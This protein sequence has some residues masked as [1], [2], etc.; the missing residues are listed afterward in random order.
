MSAANGVPRVAI[1]GGGISGLAAALRLRELAQEQVRPLDVHLL[2]GGE[3][4]G[5]VIATERRDG[6]LLEAGP[7]SFIT[8]KP[9]ALDL[10]RRLGLS[11]RLIGT[12][13]AHRRSYVARAGRLYPVPEGFQLLA[14][15]R[16]GP[17]L[18]SGLFSWPGKLRMALEPFVPAR[19]SGEDE[20]LAEFVERRLGR[21]AL[22]RIAQPMVAGIYGADP[23]R[24][25]LQATLP[26]FLKMEQEHGSLL[27]AMWAA[28]RR[29]NPATTTENAKTRRREEHEEGSST[30]TGVSGARY[31]LF[32]SFDDGMQT[33]VDALVARLPAGCVSLGTRI[34]GLQREQANWQ[35]TTIPAASP[36]GAPLVGALSATYDAVCLALP[37]HRTA[38]LLADVDAGLAEQLRAIPY[39]SA[40]TVNLAYRREDVPHPLDGFGFVVPSAEGR[41]LL[42]CTFSSV[43]FAC[44][45]P[46]G[47]VLL[48]AFLGGSPSPEDAAV[49]AAVREDLRVLLGITAAPHLVTIH[50]WAASMAHYTVGHLA[51]VAAIEERTC[52]WPG[53]ALA[54]NGY[55]GIGIPDCVHSGEQAAEQ[56]WE[57][58]SARAS[59]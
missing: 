37:A 55:R 31:G 32:V 14:P 17:F 44:R 35:L 48:R 12:N 43:K 19:P 8:D 20:S 59:N 56:I 2:E 16:L 36:V 42:G 7:D 10:C 23:R 58:L 27:R 41:S 1:V 13:P 21:E 22:A 24:L 15:S 46:E 3:R 33:L 29:S 38:E 57:A 11:E 51:R 47:H 28:R 9:W 52:R 18:A 25:S 49:T 40:A 53:L 45:A 30:S 34:T 50:R 26:R 39:G 5:G 4:L 6:F 54:G